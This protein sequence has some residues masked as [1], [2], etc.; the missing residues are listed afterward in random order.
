MLAREGFEDWNYQAEKRGSQVWSQKRVALRKYGDRTSAED[1]GEKKKGVRGSGKAIFPSLSS[2]N[3]FFL[4]RRSKAIKSE[5]QQLC[6]DTSAF[7]ATRRVGIG[8]KK[9]S[10][11]NFD[12]TEGTQKSDVEARDK[13]RTRGSLWA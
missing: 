10:A 1:D 4:L 2:P 7:G 5:S 9:R 6:F 8:P 3:S 12:S 11:G 13:L